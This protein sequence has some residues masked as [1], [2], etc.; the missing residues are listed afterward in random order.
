[1]NNK[2][3]FKPNP[4]LK[5]MEQVREVLRY[6]HYS[7]RTEQ[8][9]CNWIVRF[10]KFFDFKIHPRDMG[11]PEIEK[12][13]SYLAGNDKVAISTQQQALNA[14]AFLYRHVLD[15][16]IDGFIEPVKAK[17]YSSLPV[18]MTQSEVKRVFD[19]VKGIHLLM[20]MLLYGSG[21]RLLECVRLRVKDLDIERNLI[22]IRAGKGG[23]DR[24]TIFPQ[25]LRLQMQ[26]HLAMVRKLHD[27]D[28]SDGYG[29][30]YMPEAL[31]RKY[32]K[33]AREFRWQYVFPAKRLSVDPRTG[34]TRRHH[35]LESGLQK[36]VKRAVQGA[37]ITKRV[38]CHT[39]RHSFVA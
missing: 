9:Y 20:A 19:Q 11:K 2:P 13:L 21:L 3:K 7:Y 30:T 39:F 33:S 14:I 17:R 1:M 10:L 15:Q 18:V 35:V 38:S 29:E 5:L 23:K 32:P 8:A 28:I 6:H 26:Q 16:P 37:D 22:Y 25:A 27:E 12:Y 36:A 31:S 4:E 24:T 34:I